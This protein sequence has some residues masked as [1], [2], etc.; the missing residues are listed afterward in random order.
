MYH[1]NSFY[2]DIFEKLLQHNSNPLFSDDKNRIIPTRVVMIDYDEKR[3]ILG[4]NDNIMST[5]PLKPVKSRNG[6]VLEAQIELSEGYG[7]ILFDA[8]TQSRLYCPYHNITEEK[9]DKD[10]L[11]NYPIGKKVKARIISHCYLEG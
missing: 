4:N 6:E 3:I 1:K 10:T 8:N 2:R 5:E 11:K 9:S 7:L